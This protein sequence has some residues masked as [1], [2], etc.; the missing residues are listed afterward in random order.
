LFRNEH[1]SPPFA[2]A[3]DNNNNNNNQS[4]EIRLM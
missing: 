1:F 4:A 2:I 3:Q